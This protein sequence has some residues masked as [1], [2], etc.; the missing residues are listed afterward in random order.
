VASAP[1]AI[2]I[3]CTGGGGEEAVAGDARLRPAE[4]ASQAFWDRWSDGRAELSGYEI[5]TPRYGQPREGTT[6]LIYVTEEADTRTWIKN[7]RGNVPDRYNTVVLKLNH[8]TTF[9]TGIYPY[10]VMTSVFS[11]VGGAGRE[12]FA[13]TKISFSAQEWCGHVYHSI[14]PEVDRFRSEIHS[15]FSVE[16]DETETVETDP[17]TL[18]EDALW[19]QLRELDG[20]FEEG[21]NWSGSM[22]PSMWHRRRSHG[23]LR[24]VSTTITRSDADRDGVP[25]TRFVVSYDGFSRTLDVEKGPS[26]GILGW[27]TSEGEEATLL[28]TVRLPYWKL[29]ANGDESYLTELGL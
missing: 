28:K 16:G 9:R 19:I 21:G 25:V 10:S 17:F 12:R 6:V 18:Y 22:V 3:S 23:P 14:W 4:P 8:V 2:L 27:T 13:P 26:R 24:A 5:V 7:D 20:P 11:P 29:N 1:L 15:Y